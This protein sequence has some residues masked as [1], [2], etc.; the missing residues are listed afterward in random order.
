M[1][2]A[3]KSPPAPG[4]P[5]VPKAVRVTGAAYPGNPMEEFPCLLLLLPKPTIL[6]YYYILLYTIN[7]RRVDILDGNMVFSGTRTAVARSQDA[8]ELEM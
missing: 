2:F 4:Q 7:S 5:V 8:L 3:A 1:A 6:I